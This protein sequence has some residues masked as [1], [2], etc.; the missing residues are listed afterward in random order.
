MSAEQP[1]QTFTSPTIIYGD[2]ATHLARSLSSGEDLWLTLPDLGA[3]TEW[4]LKPEGVCRGDVCIP[5]PPDKPDTLLVEDRGE[6]WFNLT[7][8]ARLLEQPY[9]HDA[10]HSVWLFGAPHEEWQSRLSSLI[11]PDFILPDLDGETHSLSDFR[12]KKV[13]LLCWASW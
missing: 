13:F 9:A 7:E 3:C 6:S 8:L 2:T 12:G 5:I 1:N 4:E 10:E 11:A